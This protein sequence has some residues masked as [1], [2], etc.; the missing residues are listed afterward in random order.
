MSTV[1]IY[2]NKLTANYSSNCNFKIKIVISTSP[3][4]ES[5]ENKHSFKYEKGSSVV[6][7]C[8]KL[9]LKSFSSLTSETKLHFFLEVYTLKGYKTAGIGVF[10]LSRGVMANEPIEIEIQ[11]CPLGKSSLEIQFLNFKLKPSK[12]AK[13]INIPKI[14]S[15]NDKKLLNNHNSNI[16]YITNIEP[17]NNEENICYSSRNKSPINIYNS[18]K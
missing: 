3:Y 9:V 13:R 10:H 8:D 7:I 16:N 18:K 17:I 4:K 11:K 14:G 15:S 12:S 6:N 5:A 1:E 2:I